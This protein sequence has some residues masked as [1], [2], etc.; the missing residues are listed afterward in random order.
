MFAQIYAGWFLNS[1][2][3]KMLALWKKKRRWCR[4]Q[5]IKYRNGRQICNSSQA[6]LQFS[7]QTPLSKGDC[8][9]TSPLEKPPTRGW[10]WG[11]L[12]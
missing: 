2:Q 3:V 8:I 10:K 12:Y 11:A 6:S 1:V 7:S 9:F 4:A 5:K